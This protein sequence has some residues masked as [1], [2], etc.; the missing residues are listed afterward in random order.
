MGR[1]QSVLITDQHAGYEF[2]INRLYIFF[3]SDS[4]I[5]YGPLF[6]GIDK[7]DQLIKAN[8][9][10]DDQNP[11]SYF[12]DVRTGS[13]PEMFIFVIQQSIKEVNSIY[14]WSTLENAEAEAYDVNGLWEILWDKTGS[15]YIVNGK[16]V[17]L[18]SQRCS[19]KAYD[20]EEL[21]ENKSE[22]TSTISNDRG[23]RFDF[24][25]HN[26]LIFKQYISLGFSYITFV[27]KDK[28]ENNDPSIRKNL[29]DP[30]PY[31]YIFNKGTSFLDDD[32]VF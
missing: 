9:S 21:G 22:S 20:F 32:F 18:N 17:I 16:K 11:D 28:I 4:Q 5:L 31:N 25:N 30:M 1:L 3:W 19:V 26:W 14:T 23:H 13:N 8:I 15:A 7:E 24:K 2:I 10:I 27:I 6:N 12:K 29:F